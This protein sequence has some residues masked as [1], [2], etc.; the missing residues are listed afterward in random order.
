V[1][2]STNP[3]LPIDRIGIF[4]S[5]ASADCH[6][7]A[8]TLSGPFRLSLSS[9]NLQ[10]LPPHQVHTPFA[11]ANMKYCGQRP[12]SIHITSIPRLR[13][14]YLSFSLPI[15]VGP[16]YSH[17]RFALIIKT[18]AAPEPFDPQ[19]VL[20]FPL[21]QAGQFNIRD[22]ERALKLLF[23]HLNAVVDPSSKNGRP[24]LDLTSGY[25]GLY[26]EYQNLILQSPNVDCRIVASSPKASNSFFFASC[27]HTFFL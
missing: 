19:K 23:E 26:K 22:E 15:S 25:F 24:L 1:R 18:D 10:H 16:L 3:I 5:L 12:K 11:K 4:T 21:I 17:V 27:T 7:I 14:P 8:S 6:N 2:I 9:Y 13:E 20:M